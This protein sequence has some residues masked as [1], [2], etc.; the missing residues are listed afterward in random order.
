M[1]GWW[2]QQ[3]SNRFNMG[4]E[5]IGFAGAQSWQVS[6]P[7]VIATVSYEAAISVMLDASLPKLRAKSTRL[8]GYLEA[9]LA[10]ICGVV[11]REDGKNVEKKALIQITPRSVDARGCQLSI[12]FPFN[13]GSV[14]DALIKV[15]A[16]CD[17][18]KPDV[19][20]ISP[21][22]LYNTFRDVFSFVRLLKKTVDEIH[23]SQ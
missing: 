18:R 21:T 22:P 19:L 8:T 5:W 4:G 9:L 17:V 1:T 15:G 2:G 14:N 13:V 23:P 16:V 20:R 7:N 10:L 12:L 6:N 3:L 11:S